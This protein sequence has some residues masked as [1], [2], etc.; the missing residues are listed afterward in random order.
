MAMTD[1]LQEQVGQFCTYS[2][3][4]VHQHEPLVRLDR[5]V[6]FPAGA[7]GWLCVSACVLEAGGGGLVTAE[8]GVGDLGEGQEGVG[9]GLPSQLHLL[10]NLQCSILAN[11]ANTHTLINLYGVCLVKVQGI[12]VYLLSVTLCVTLPW[13]KSLLF[14]MLQR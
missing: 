6:D 3:Q 2:P 8:E 7:G 9:A 1:N 12:L 4:V 11:E 10:T 5:L 13:P 14:E